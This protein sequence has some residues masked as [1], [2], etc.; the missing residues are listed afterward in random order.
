MKT[1]RAYWCRIAV[2]AVTFTSAQICGATE[3]ASTFPMWT[4][5]AGALGSNLSVDE[6]IHATNFWRSKLGFLVD[7]ELRVSRWWGFDLA[8][9]DLRLAVRSISN[10]TF[11]PSVETRSDVHMRPLLLSAV[12]HPIEHGVVDLWFG[13]AAGTVFYRSELGVQSDSEG[14]VGAVVGV[15]VPILRSAW[16]ATAGARYLRTRVLT[17]EAGTLIVNPVLFNAGLSYSW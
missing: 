17:S 7:G 9:G 6:G 11:S 8:Y 3:T 5:R 13:P 1:R 14:A 12:V 15:S 16:A 2:C 4:L 10:A